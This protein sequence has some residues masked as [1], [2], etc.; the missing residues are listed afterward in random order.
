MQTYLTDNV[1]YLKFELAK[2][3]VL[4]LCFMS[5]SKTV[6]ITKMKALIKNKW[7]RRCY[8]NERFVPSEL[9]VGCSRIAQAS[10]K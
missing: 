2:H 4:S 3:H 1:L 9:F 7:N 10:T 6:L 5:R 8:L